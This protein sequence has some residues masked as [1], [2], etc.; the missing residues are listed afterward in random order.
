MQLNKQQRGVL[1]KWLS[2]ISTYVFTAMP[3]GLFLSGGNMPYLV[4]IL[5]AII[6]LLL[7]GTAMF[8]N[9][10]TDKDEV[11]RT[12]VKKGIFHVENAEIKR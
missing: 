11:M 3:V 12:E 4:Y 9:R 10:K 2:D 8:I 5:L 1:T 7:L 6:G